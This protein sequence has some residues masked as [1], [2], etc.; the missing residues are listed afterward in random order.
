M[1]LDKMVFKED[2]VERLQTKIKLVSQDTNRLYLQLR[3]QTNNWGGIPLGSDL[4]RAQTLINELTV[5]AEKL[6]DIIR[7]AVKGVQ[8]AQDENKRQANQLFQ[9]LGT[10]GG[11]F[12]KL[13]GGSA[14]GQFPIPTYAQKMVTKL[15]TSIASLMGRDELNSDPLV[16]KLQTTVKNSGLG[17][18]DSI[19]AHSKLKDI[20]QARDQI[21]KAQTAYKVYQAF[22]NKTQMDAMHK[23]A[24]DARQ[25]LKYLGIDE[26]HYQAGKDLSGYFKK[27]V[28]KACDYDPSITSSSVPLV[29]NE[30]YLLMLR[31]A[32]E[33]GDQGAWAKRQLVGERLN[34]PPME[35]PDGTPI[36]AYNN[37]NEI[38]LNYFNA[39]V[40]KP[41]ETNSLSAYYLW[42][43]STYGMTEWRK[44]V[45]Q[46]DAVTRAFMGSLIE[47]TVMGVVDTVT[48]TFHFIIDPEK[49]T[50]EMADTASYIMQHPEVLAEAAKKMYHNFNEGTPEEKASMLG[51]AASV[52]VPGLSVTKGTKVGKV[53]D[54]V[55]DFATKAME[56]VKD[57]NK[58]LQNSGHLA[59]LPKFKPFLSTSEGVPFSVGKIPLDSNPLPKT[60]VQEHYIN[61]MNGFGDVKGGKIEGTGDFDYKEWADMPVSGQVKLAPNGQ[62]LISIRDLKLFTKDMNGKSIKVVID[63]KG[64]ILPD[65]A[66]GGFDPRTGQIVLKKDPTYLSAMHE[67]YHA[68]QWIEIGKEKYLKLSTLE[69][70]EY[71]YN[72]IM[73]NKDLY[74]SE[75]ILFSQRYIYKL[76]NGEWPPPEWK[77]VE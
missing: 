15:I 74:T 70:E 6:E 41:N 46:A 37:E 48:F 33:P 52:L 72:K 66:A 61:E 17:T 56:G 18:I 53:A 49:T 29:Q 36:T 13:G 67:S 2:E 50:Q 25:K 57:L 76:R 40:L 26:V 24:E 69:R 73:K 71:V 62:R 23:L 16:Q 64:K 44:K 47:E 4:I 51:A 31:M 28:V 3:G 7:L 38:T 45:V 34:I 20:Y 39:H 60:F 9:Q 14:S 27:P 55:Q 54:G 21:A 43:E 19:A 1:A 77:G 63:E 65:F 12:G 32:M 8:G 5:E 35:L 75:E 30:S 11:M 22:G 58:V 42:L 68:K 10:L 59:E